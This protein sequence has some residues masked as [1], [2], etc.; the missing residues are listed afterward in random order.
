L[1][2]QQPE[3]TVVIDI[4]PHVIFLDAGEYPRAPV[5]GQDTLA[6]LPASQRQWIFRDTAESLYPA[7]AA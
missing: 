4:H 5:G 2:P 7:L 3:S 1:Q 6:F